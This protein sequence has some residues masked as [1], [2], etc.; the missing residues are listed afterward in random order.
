MMHPPGLNATTERGQG[1]GVQRERVRQV[2]EAG[3]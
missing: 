1:N 2:T 3:S